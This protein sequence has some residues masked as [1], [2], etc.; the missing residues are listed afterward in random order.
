M[1]D[2][3]SRLAEIYKSEKAKG[4]GLASTFGKRA[5][6]KIDPRQMFDQKGLLAAALPSV[7]KAY[8]ATPADKVKELSTAQSSSLG[9]V[10]GLISEF[11]DVK[12]SSKISAK[13]SMS[14]PDMARDMNVMRQNIITLVKQQGGET[15]NKADMYFKKSSENEAAYESQFRK[16][17]IKQSTSPTQQVPKKEDGGLLSGISSAL[18]G[19]LSG[20]SSTLSSI[21][22]LENIAKIFGGSSI[23]SG[24]MKLLPIITSGPFLA[25]IGGII[26]AKWLMD[27]IDKKNS[28][29]NTTQKMNDRVADDRGSQS[30]KVAARTIRIDEGLKSLLKDDRTDEEVSAYT[31]GEIRTKDELRAKIA[32]AEASGKRA[33][34]I[35]DSR[36]VEEARQE[37]NKI[38][39][40]M[41]AEIGAPE[42]APL[43]RYNPAA[44][45]QAANTT[46]SPTP[47][48]SSG[49]GAGR[50]GQGGPTAEQL[51]TPTQIPSGASTG[52]N[53]EFK[54]KQDFLTAMYPLAVKASEKLGGVD[55]NALLTQWGFESA[56]GSKTSGK[57]NY[58]GIK[59]DKNWSG[60]KKDV[61]THEYLQGEKVTLPQPFRS[62]GSPEEAVDDYVNFLKNNKRYERAGVFQAKTSGEYFG[63]LQ[64]AGYA[65]DP[66]YAN[67]LTSATES[68][69]K[70]IAML[71]LPTPS[72]GS[73]LSSTSTQVASASGQ[74][75]PTIV[76]NNTTNNTMASA[77][78]KPQGTSTIPSAFDDVFIALLGRVT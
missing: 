61:M 38:A 20:I 6:E 18:G 66:N 19:L 75:G 49:A 26:A 68:T 8:K 4:G 30:S 59:A 57:Y 1:A 11:R 27:L 31:R 45:S 12:I 46:I 71:N 15:T 36:V 43:P 44:D 52:P 35:K 54:S 39:D 60:D 56:W 67:K 74:G 5:L 78:Q 58:F 32:E 47:M 53:G 9:N 29:A 34:E 28:E 21:F 7:F 40:R 33:I 22:S 17:K 70:N 23:I 10:D 14:L 63:A 13:N 64:K 2:K 25:L 41:D 77:G 42:P 65:T 37:R 50:G 76:N 16:E 3:T 73:A 72:T 51:N 55:P 69:G 62:Y 48:K 24:L